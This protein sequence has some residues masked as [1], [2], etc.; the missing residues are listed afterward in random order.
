MSKGSGAVRSR[1][2]KHFKQKSKKLRKRH[3]TYIRIVH[4]DNHGW[5]VDRELRCTHKKCGFLDRVDSAKE[6]RRLGIR[7]ERLMRLRKQRKKA[8]KESKV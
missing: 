1:R 8:Q 7:H 3:I 4:R 6:G 5:A 2:R